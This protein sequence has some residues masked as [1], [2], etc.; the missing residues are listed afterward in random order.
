MTLNRVKLI[1]VRHKAMT[2]VA[3][4]VV[5]LGAALGI[6]LGSGLVM[7]EP[8]PLALY[9]GSLRAEG[10]PLVSSVLKEGSSGARLEVT[11]TVAAADDSITA[12]DKENQ[13]TVI[14]QAALLKARGLS[15][16]EVALTL[17][18]SS[19]RVVYVMERPLDEGIP[20]REEVAAPDA[21]ALT[22][23]QAEESLLSDY[24]LS[25]LRLRAVRDSQT[26]DGGLVLTVSLVAVDREAAG[27][28]LERLLMNF[29]WDLPGRLQAESLPVPAVIK[30]NVLDESGAP[31][32]MYTADLELNHDSGWF[33]PGMPRPGLHPYGPPSSSV[34]AADGE[35][36]S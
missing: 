25:G 19:G 20:P 8:D 17:V 34:P 22:L 7:A 10:V 6:L 13:H 21:T 1:V 35:E 24:D 27:K 18:D 31:L 12:Q 23:K 4:A 30:F 32:V 33:A 28:S 9:S 3:A 16:D 29:R 11:L 5:V 14:R 2:A 15:V 36:G 26:A